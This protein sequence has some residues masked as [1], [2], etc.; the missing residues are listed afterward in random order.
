VKTISR[1]LLLIIFLFGGAHS[2][3]LAQSIQSKMKNL[4]ENSD[5]ILEG[6]VVKQNSSWNQNKTRIYT[7]VTV[8][9]DEYLKG[10]RGNKTLIVTTPGG[11]VGEVGELYSHMPSFSK[12]E[13]VLLFVKKDKKDESYKVLNGEEGKLTLYRDK[14]TGEKVT[15]FNKKIST[16]KKEIKNYVDKHPQE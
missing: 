1:N 5:V 8:E 12:D 16:L 11:E 10:N 6:K 14:K 9:V 7:E 3:L 2:L 13:E 4:S 15:S